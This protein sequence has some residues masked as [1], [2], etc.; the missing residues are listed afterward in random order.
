[1]FLEF[2][3]HLRQLPIAIQLFTGL[4]LGAVFVVLIC[5][6]V[7]Y[8]FAVPLETRFLPANCNYYLR[9][10]NDDGKIQ[11]LADKISTDLGFY[12]I[13]KSANS[14]IFSVCQIS[15]SDNLIFIQAKDRSIEKIIQDAGFSFNKIGKGKYIISKSPIKIVN[16]QRLSS[17]IIG[18]YR[19]GYNLFFLAPH[20]FISSFNS[21]L[22][23]A[24]CQDERDCIVGGLA[25]DNYLKIFSR[26]EADHDIKNI[27]LGDYDYIYKKSGNSDLCDKKI[28]EN[29]DLAVPIWVKL[30]GNE[31]YETFVCSDYVFGVKDREEMATSTSP[32]QRYEIFLQ[33]TNSEDFTSEQ[34]NQ[35]EFYLKK[36]IS[37]LFPFDEEIVLSD[38]SR[39][40]EIR[41]DPN[42]LEFQ[43]TSTKYLEFPD[44]SATIYYVVS[45]SKAII[46]NNIDVI[47]SPMSI[48]GDNL[49]ITKTTS[50]N[51]QF[52]SP[53]VSLYDI[54]VIFDDAIYLK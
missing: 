1:M 47:G 2:L 36:S 37:K 35:L 46:A 21:P 42:N 22:L 49:L 48:K 50:I 33:L 52:L 40:V 41:V 24:L 19:S 17:K 54:L 27:S 34:I 10:N 4:A 12:D 8:F 14:G 7:N 30:I 23:S 53:Y 13:Y 6:L 11:K 44:N 18:Q 5:L 25:D 16:Q 32:W 9:I 3:K 45:G 20:G 43:G 31:D 29:I 38:G 51:D 15:S 26:N 39:V 28:T